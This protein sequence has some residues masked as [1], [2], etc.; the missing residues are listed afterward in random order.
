[1]QEELINLFQGGGVYS[2]SNLTNIAS[3]CPKGV[4]GCVPV[5]SGS[6]TGRHYTSYTQ[7]FD[8]NGIGGAI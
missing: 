7:A 5:A 2:Y 4:V 8:L 3:D 1:V 6:A